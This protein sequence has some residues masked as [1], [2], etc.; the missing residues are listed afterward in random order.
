MPYCSDLRIEWT[1]AVMNNA[2]ALF[3]YIANNGI[4]IYLFSP[5]LCPTL[6]EGIVKKV[7]LSHLSS[8]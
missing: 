8:A 4:L 5:C 6:A 7:S 3:L 2:V 1:Q